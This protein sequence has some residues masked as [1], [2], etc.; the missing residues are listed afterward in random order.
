MF[1]VF[2]KILTF[3]IQPF[4]W[5][6]V[7]FILGLTFKSKVIKKRLLL[8]SLITLLFF[9]NSLIFNFFSYQWETELSDPSQVKDTFDVAV[10]L[11]GMVSYNE[12]YH[13]TE[14]SANS[15]RILNIL[16]LYFKGQI[17][18][19]LI[20]GGSG[21]L[22]QQEKEAE[23][24]GSYLQKIGIN[25][26]DIIMETRSRNTY[27]NALYSAEI[28]QSEFSGAKVLLSTSTTHMRRAKA[29]FNAQKMGCTTFSVDRVNQFEEL[30]IFD[31]LKVNPILFDRWY[32]L[33]HEWVGFGIYRMKGY[34]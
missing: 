6:V 14:F 30:K 23:V 8:S 3:L 34:C 10:V 27:E 31:I 25:A 26:A 15:D 5:V 18:K 21:S 29:C 32:W 13:L 4:T 24:L 7:L 20:S 33:I 11:G 1:F 19:I 28:I 9:S 16:P 2:S 17:K 12:M 22:D